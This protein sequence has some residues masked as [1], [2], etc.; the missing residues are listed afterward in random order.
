MKLIQEFL[1]EIGFNITIMV[2]GIIGGIIGRKKDRPMWEQIFSVFTSAFIANYTAPLIIEL[3]G[4]GQNTIGGVG[5][6]A[7]YSGKTMLDYLFEKFKK[8][9]E[10]KIEE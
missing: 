5:F 9:V 2:G 7:G 4:L 10:E 6:I 3:F 8:K 1:N